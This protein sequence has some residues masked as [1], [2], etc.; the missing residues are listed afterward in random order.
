MS[1]KA[2]EVHSWLRPHRGISASSSLCTTHA[3]AA[4]PCSERLSPAWWRDGPGTTP[5]PNKSQ[6]GY[7]PVPAAL[8]TCRSGG[9]TGRPAADTTAGCA[10]RDCGPACLRTCVGEVGHGRLLC[11]TKRAT[12]RCS[13]V[14]QSRPSE[15]GEVNKH[16]ARP[17]ALGP[18][19]S[20]RPNEPTDQFSPS[21]V[22]ARDVFSW[23]AIVLAAAGGSDQAYGDGGTIAAPWADLPWLEG[24]RH[25]KPCLVGHTPG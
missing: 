16:R 17:N 20:F 22:I 7:R 14:A 21:A 18:T 3:D 11:E 5:E 8:A 6:P 19:T 2:T 12:G 10:A 13:I 9:R 25:G 23:L 24:W 1:T 15:D 4:K